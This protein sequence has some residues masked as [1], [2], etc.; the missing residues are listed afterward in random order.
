MLMSGRLQRLLLAGTC[1]CVYGTPVHPPTVP[2]TW[3]GSVT[4][5]GAEP[6]TSDAEHVAGPIL[7]VGAGGAG[8]HGRPGGTDPV[9]QTETNGDGLGGGSGPSEEAGGEARSQSEETKRF[10]S[11][12]EMGDALRPTEAGPGPSVDPD[13]RR[14]DATVINQPMLKRSDTVNTARDGFLASPTEPPQLSITAGEAGDPGEADRTKP[15]PET[16]SPS[17]TE[18]PN[19]GAATQK[20]ASHSSMFVSP[21]TSTHVS[22]WDHDETMSS[23]PDP[24]LPEIGPN[25]MPTGDGPESLWTEA[26]RPSGGESERLEKREC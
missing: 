25:L 7:N 14:E 13:G 23:L 19:P 16:S 18:P 20:L 22:I 5:V 15:D 1:L 17:T 4:S 9:T 11:S 3:D 21:Q 6:E 26:A 10:G 24:L 12:S 8:P 2:P